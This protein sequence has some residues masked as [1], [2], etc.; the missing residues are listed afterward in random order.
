MALAQIGPM[1]TVFEAIAT[2]VSAGVVLGSF[3]MGVAGLALGWSRREIGYRALSD[4]YMGGIAG[5]AVA[6]FNLA[7][8]YAG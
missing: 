4:G 8:R 2:A 3:T 5:V 1:T 6:F 7:I